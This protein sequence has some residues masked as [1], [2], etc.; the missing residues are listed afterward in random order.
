MRILA[1]DDERI[2]LELLTASIREA[3]PEAE[4]FS[5]NDPQELLAFAG[6]GRA[7]VAFL[8]IQ[9]FG[10]TGL[11]LAKRLKDLTPEINIIFVTGYSQY[12]GDAL[13]LRASG[14]VMKPTT[15]EMIETELENLRRPVAENRTSRLQVQCFGNFEV[16]A[17]G[18]PVRYEFSRTKE[19]FAYLVDR[20]G[21]ADVFLKTRNN[22]AVA[23]DAMDCDYY[24]FLSGDTAAVNAYFGEYMTQYSWAELTL[25]SLEVKTRR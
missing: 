7:D 5:F 18:Q 17:D 15:K 24:R 12:T 9:M 21:A 11:E 1:C 19:L 16:Y 25:G 23:R 2:P 4:L 20:A 3:R 6:Q 13:K 14:Y 8:D 22:F 10:M